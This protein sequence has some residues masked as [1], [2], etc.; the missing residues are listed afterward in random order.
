MVGES[1]MVAPIIDK[2]ATRRIVYFP[3][4]K[5]IEYL[6]GKVYKG[7]TYQMIEM[8]ID[9]VGIFIKKN[10]LIAQTKETL[11]IKKEQ[12]DELILNLFGDKGSCLI[13]DDDGISLDY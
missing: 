8:P 13:Y 3:K 6:T 2:D 12:Q 1:I 4:G 5:W 7:N 10:S 11:H 9:Y